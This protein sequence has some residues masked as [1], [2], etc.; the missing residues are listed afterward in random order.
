MQGKPRRWIWITLLAVLLLPFA[1]CMAGVGFRLVDRGFLRRWVERLTLSRDGT[2][3]EALL[4]P[5]QVLPEGW[6][7]DPIN[8][9]RPASALFYGQQ[10]A[11]MR[12]FRYG[13]DKAREASGVSHAVARYPTEE[14]AHRDYL[15]HQR[16][17][18]GN[19]DPWAEMEKWGYE[20]PHAHE[21][22]LEFAT[23]LRK[24]GRVGR[25]VFVARYG[26]YVSELVLMV[27]LED[28]NVEQ[29]KALVVAADEMFSGLRDK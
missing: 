15:V 8:T 6:R 24:G 4:L 3:P 19:L 9:G 13:T 28:M 25:C 11:A 12:G 1:C 29:V 14:T 18:F 10:D 5:P 7:A 16:S 22:N 23:E 20:S 2:S 17:T 27:Y 21:S 26:R